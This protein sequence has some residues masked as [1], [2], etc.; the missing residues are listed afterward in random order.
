[1]NQYDNIIVGNIHL[2]VFYVI[3]VDISII[4]SY[5]W[6]NNECYMISHGKPSYIEI[7]GIK[8]YANTFV[9]NIH[10]IDLILDTAYR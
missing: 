10:T 2:Y 4:V 8:L 7:T 5:I 1:M 3:Y 6:A 9:I